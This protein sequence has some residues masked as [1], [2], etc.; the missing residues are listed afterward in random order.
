[1]NFAAVKTRTLR[2]V[3]RRGNSPPE[4]QT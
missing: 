1:M 3:K 2:G 4:L